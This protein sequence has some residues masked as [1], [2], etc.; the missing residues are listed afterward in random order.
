MRISYLEDG[1]GQRFD[2]LKFV[3]AVIIVANHTLN[4]PLHLRP[5]VRLAVPL[6]FIMTSYFFHL[7]L[8][9]AR[10]PAE[11]HERLMKFVKRNFKLYL[12]WS[13][14]LLPIVLYLRPIW[15]EY[16][17]LFA[18]KKII[19]SFLLGFFPA[20]WFI[21]AS[22]Y[23]T[24]IVYFLSRWF[25]NRWLFVISLLVYIPALLDSS[26]VGLMS[27]SAYES[28]RLFGIHWNSNFPAAMV[29]IV[30]G[31]I[32]AE[33]PLFLSSKVLYPL[34]FLFSVLVMAENVWVYYNIHPD[35]GNCM[36][37]LIPVATLLFVAIAQ[38]K[39][40][41]CSNSLWLR[42]SSIIIYCVHKSIGDAIWVTY[43]PDISS[44]LQFWISLLSSL[45]IA[46]LFIY[47]HEKKNVRILK[48]S[49]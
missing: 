37:F 33:K 17:L 44:V 35:N 29:W 42:K 7:K 9:E 27:P 20:S 49:Y 15:F 24:V 39:D 43:Y 4:I 46:A 41:S 5:F 31:K 14:L 36:V 16:D 6:F 12:F 11:S 30:I 34:I 18:V 26:Y 8:K 10:T 45:F 32:L 13:I 1:K 40:I 48:Y 23:A 28:L 2:V 25:R 38:A 21:V 19:K 22:V 47:L 3:M